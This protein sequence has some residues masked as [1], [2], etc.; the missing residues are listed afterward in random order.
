MVVAE[1]MNKPVLKVSMDSESDSSSDEESE[2]SENNEIEENEEAED[3]I[4]ADAE[5]DDDEHEGEASDED[6]NE[7]ASDAESDG[8]GSSQDASDEDEDDNDGP[9]VTNEGWADS[10][11]KILGSTKPKNKKTLVLSRAKKHSEIVKAVKEEKPA[12]EVIGD[13]TEE[14]KPVV[15]KKEAEV[16]EPPAKKVKHEK[17]SIRVKPN[18]LEKDRER[19]LTKIATKGVVQLFNAVRNQQKTIEKEMDRNDLSEGKKEKIL[20]KFDKRAFLDTLMGQS[21]SVIVDEEAK[22]AKSEVKDEDK[23]KWSALRDDFMMGAKMKDWDKE[24]VDE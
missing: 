7:E 16:S 13:E 22:V 18:I 24:S 19:I 1:T 17:P 6:E 2:A 21:K 10:V 23:P 4:E 8:A 20:K 9:L 3:G 12:F 14:K 15:L 5:S 11:A